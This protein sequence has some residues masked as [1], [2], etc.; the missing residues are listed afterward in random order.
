MSAVRILVGPH[1]YRLTQRDACS[2]LGLSSASRFWLWLDSLEPGY[3]IFETG[4]ES[5]PFEDSIKFNVQMETEPLSCKHGSTWGWPSALLVPPKYGFWTSRWFWSLLLW[6]GIIEVEPYTWRETRDPA[7]S[8][9]LPLGR[10]TCKLSWTTSNT[11]LNVFYF[12]HSRIFFII[13]DS[14]SP[15]HVCSKSLMLSFKI[16]SFLID[17]PCTW[18]TFIQKCLQ[19]SYFVPDMVLGSGDSKLMGHSSCP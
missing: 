7:R 4:R 11:L 18:R 16:H 5:D 12:R 8:R 10:W 17:S 3:L 6:D 19:C 14:Q 9:R 2:H 13:P 1:R 15:I